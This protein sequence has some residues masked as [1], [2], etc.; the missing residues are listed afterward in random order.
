MR[1]SRRTTAYF[2]FSLLIFSSRAKKADTAHKS[3]DCWAITA[4]GAPHRGTRGSPTTRKPTRVPLPVQSRS[5]G[6]AGDSTCQTQ[7]GRGLGASWV[8]QVTFMKNSG[9]R[10]GA[11]LS[12]CRRKPA[13]RPSGR[14]LPRPLRHTPRDKRRLAG[15]HIVSCKPTLH[16]R[17]QVPAGFTSSPT[18]WS[19]T[20]ELQTFVVRP[21]LATLLPGG[22]LPRCHPPACLLP[23][24]RTFRSTSA[25]VC[26]APLGAATLASGC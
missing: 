3:L 16:T 22:V 24:G 18:T 2:P 7:Q 15:A 17:R 23:H 1:L 19:R 12:M 13:L 26:C 21:R 5:C 20:V 11:T 25:G 6:R 8:R 4:F 10:I 14:R 9:A